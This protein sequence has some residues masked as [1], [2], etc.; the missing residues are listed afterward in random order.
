MTLQNCSLSAGRLYGSRTGSFSKRWTGGP[1]KRFRTES[2]YTKCQNLTGSLT[3]ALMNNSNTWFL[4]LIPLCSWWTVCPLLNCGLNSFQKTPGKTALAMCWYRS[5]LSMFQIERK[6]T[7]ALFLL[8]ACA[9]CWLRAVFLIVLNWTLQQPH[10]KQ[11]SV[12]TFSGAASKST[13]KKSGQYV[14]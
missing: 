3:K 13:V 2:I 7:T 14:A 1:D 11:F 5:K 10:M 8:S 12:F 9:R 4:P 6:I